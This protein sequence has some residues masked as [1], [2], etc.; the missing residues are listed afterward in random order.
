MDRGLLGDIYVI[1]LWY[2][3]QVQEIKRELTGDKEV[4]RQIFEM[5]AGFWCGKDCVHVRDQGL[6]LAENR[7]ARF[8]LL[9]RA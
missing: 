1:S 4:R 3:C 9:E 8:V 7:A 6:N 5:P 2:R